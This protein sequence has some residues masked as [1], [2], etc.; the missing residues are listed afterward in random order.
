MQ[1]LPYR[2][3]KGAVICPGGVKEY[4]TFL[5]F[6][7]FEASTLPTK[8]YDPSLESLNKDKEYEPMVF[9][10][11]MQVKEFRNYAFFVYFQYLFLSKG[12]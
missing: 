2:S 4:Q 11:R 5:C 9:F 12:R 6:K 10:K 3:L 8:K 1:A 7:L